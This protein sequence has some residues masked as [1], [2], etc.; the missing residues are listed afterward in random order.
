MNNAAAHSMTSAPSKGIGKHFRMRG[1]PPSLPASDADGNV[2]FSVIYRQAGV[3]G[4]SFTA[5][6]TLD[7][8]GSLPGELPFD[9]KRQTVQVTLGAM[10]RAIGAN[11]ESI[12]SDG[13]RKINALATFAESV[14]RET[15]E[16]THSADSEI[17]ALEAQIAQKRSAIQTAEQRQAHVA[18]SC[19]NEI[20]RL[21]SVLDFFGIKKPPLHLSS[22][23]HAA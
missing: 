19:A 21:E 23:D 14:A 3:P 22:V 9:T 11:P 15:M 18:D 16:F 5:E 7:M 8:L 6:Q 13:S 10:G 4:V 17:A 12:C 1:A 20:E 2:D